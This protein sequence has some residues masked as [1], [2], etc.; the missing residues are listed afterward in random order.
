MKILIVHYRYYI[1]GGPE[2][3][4]FNL[5]Q[6][7]ES[8]GHKVIIFSRRLS[9]N[10]D[11]EYKDYWVDNIGN[12]DSIYYN[13]T[14]KSIRIYFDMFCREFYSFKSKKALKKLIK[15]T[16]PDICYLMV[17]KGV[18]SPSVI[19]ACVEMKLPIVN[20][21]SDYN[22]MCGACSLYRD[23]HLCCDCFNDN[24]ISCLRH[25]CVKNSFILSSVRY[26]SMRFHERLKMNNKIDAIVCTNGFMKEMF[27][28]RH[29]VP[30][31]K[32]HVIPTFFHQ[33]ED[34]SSL[35]KSL[36]K[37]DSGIKLLYIGNIDESKGIYDLINALAIVR[38]RRT[39]FRLYIVGGLHQEENDVMIKLIQEKQLTD[40]VSFQPFRHDGRVYDYYI[41]SHLTILPAR[42]PENLPNT[43]VESLYFHRPVV[44]PDKGSFKYTTDESIAFRYHA[45]SVDS[46]A[47]TIL[48]VLDQPDKVK[49]KSESCEDYFQINY[50]EEMHINE[51]LNLFEKFIPQ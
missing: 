39:D 1:T 11:N 13:Q 2:R 40:N 21:I 43:L 23:G 25:R 24:D 3:Y 27:L 30:E 31:E 28:K 32:L 38:K 9:Q 33:T 44:V 14:K 47:D 22:P 48:S 50:S 34:M 36:P 12:S 8:R 41:N 15:V 29:L 4:L 5:K 20:R 26:A 46:L 18:F 45:Y 16:N 7:L 35:D 37:S 51:L 6:A 49:E 42:W 17:Y 10:E 19:D